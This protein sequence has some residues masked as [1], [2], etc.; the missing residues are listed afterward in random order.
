MEF[1]KHVNLTTDFTRQVIERRKAELASE[2]PEASSPGKK[3]AFLDFLLKSQAE[4]QLSDED[5]REEVDTF[6]FEGH[7]TTSSGITFAIWFLGQHP[8]YQVKVQEELDEIFGEDY[9]RCPDS[10]DFRRMVY[11]EQCI[12]ETLRI[13]PPVPFVSRKLVEDVVIREFQWQSGSYLHFQPTL[14]KI[15]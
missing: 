8:E 11:L 3:L 4:Y 14:P 13:T 2:T 15:P 12:K 6:M 5:I 1:Q 9:E 10:E 7:D